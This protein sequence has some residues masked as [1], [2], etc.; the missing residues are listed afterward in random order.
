MH[1]LRYELDIRSLPA[2]EQCETIAAVRQPVMFDESAA[3]AD[4]EDQ[5]VLA[6]E[7]CKNWFCEPEAFEVTPVVSHHQSG[8]IHRRRSGGKH[9][10]AS[11]HAVLEV[12]LG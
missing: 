3:D 12:H 6:V 8:S 11:D 5:S 9:I 2:K 10:A 4:V 7:Q 1:N